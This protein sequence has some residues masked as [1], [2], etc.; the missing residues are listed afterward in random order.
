M[1]SPFD[2]RSTAMR[3]D[4]ARD[5]GLLIRERR[6]SLGLSQKRLAELAGVGRQWVVAVEGGKETVELGLVLRLMK[7]LGL[8][9][10]VEPP[11]DVAKSGGVAL[12]DILAHARSPR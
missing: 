5:I 3:A 2:D 8:G 7:G 1:V 11:G 12:E 6:R 4:T 9:V 10:F